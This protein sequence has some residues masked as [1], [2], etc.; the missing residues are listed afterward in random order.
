[1]GRI[2]NFDCSDA[3]EVAVWLLHEASVSHENLA[4]AFAAL[5]VAGYAIERV[6]DDAIVKALEGRATTA[7]HELKLSKRQD[8]STMPNTQ[9][10]WR[11]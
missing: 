11:A 6:G 1:L 3:G 2:H 10:L 7:E 4:F 5:A 8:G 9:P